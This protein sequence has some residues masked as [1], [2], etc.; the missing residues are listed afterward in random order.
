MAAPYAFPANTPFDVVGFGLNSVDHLCVVQR[1]PR[2]DSKQPLVTYDV[3]P[4]GQVPTALVALQR[5]G[6]RTAYVGSFGDDVGGMMSRESL[7]SEGVDVTAC[8]TRSDTRQQVSVILIDEV[9]GERS[10]LWQ[11]VDELVLRADEVPHAVLT[12]GRVLLMDTVD[13]PTAIDAARRAKQHGILTVLDTDSPAAGIDELLQLTDVLIV[14]AEF[15]ARLT[16]VA[17]LRDALRQTAK[18]GP[19]FVGVTL[20][21]GGALAFVQGEFQYV[22]AFRVPVVD[23][24]GAGDIFHAGSIYG[25][26]QGWPVPDTLRFAAAAAALKCEKLGGRPG[27]PTLERAQALAGIAACR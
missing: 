2:L 4:G 22:P 9:S 21:P 7:V 27:I 25:L 1:H 3:Q 16:G 20:G 26:L 17:D 10:V 6:L 5:W 14:A 12:A 24:T 8:V 19:W 15:P 18:R 23:S 11:R 13:M